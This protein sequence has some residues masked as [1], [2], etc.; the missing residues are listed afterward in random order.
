MIYLDNAATT[1][2]KP[3]RVKQAVLDALD[4]PVNI[5][6]NSGKEAFFY[7]D[8]IL[9]VREAIGNLLNV[10]NYE[11][12]VFTNNASQAL[13]FA[14]KGFCR[15]KD[16]IIT[17]PFEHNSVLRQLFASNGYRVSI[18][19]CPDGKTVDF[20][21]MKDLVQ[22]KT[23]LLIVN[24]VSNVTGRMQPYRSI[25]QFAEEAGIAVLFDLSQAVGNLEI[26]LSDFHHCMAAFSGHKSL[27][28]PQGTGVLYVSEDIRL[29]N[30]WE[31]GTGS[32]SNQLLQP[33]FLPDQ[34]EVGTLNTPGILG[35][36]EGV[37]YVLQQS[38]SQLLQ[39]KRELCRLA[40]DNLKE[41]ENIILYHDGDFQKH[42]G[43]L[44]FNIGT[45]YSEQVASL[46]SE[47]YQ[48]ST[49]GGFHCA[50]LMHRVIGTKSQGA[51]RISPGYQ[52]TK[53]EIFRLIDAVYHIT[54]K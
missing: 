16:H 40:Y 49:R 5:G 23:R 48:I 13:N 19:P 45:L 20:S 31:G 2:Q 54:K 17:T 30:V 22:P 37:R 47:E 4:H 50:P 26:D 35:L 3:F 21:H 41:M 15:P 46:L 12:I 14:V 38:P 7:A 28:G 11:S 52:T 33:D 6:R 18:L 44:S 43:I 42:V 36:G 32:L 9:S 27:L 34:L 8:K 53:N 10:S 24:V 51:V 25:Y 1:N 39:H 29:N